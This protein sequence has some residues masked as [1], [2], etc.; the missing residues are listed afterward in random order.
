[1]K[2]LVSH[3]SLYKKNGW[4]R[5]FEEAKGL[6]RLGHDVTLLCSARG[7]GRICNSQ[8]VEGVKVLAFYDII[9]ERFLLFGHG[10]FSLFNKLIY[11]VFTHFDICLSN[12]HR[13]NAYYPCALNRFFHRSK[14]VI[15]WWDDFSVKGNSIQSPNIIRRVI[16]RIINFIQPSDE[17]REISTKLSSDIVVVLSSTMARRAER[18]GVSAD[19]IRII[20]GGCDVDHLQYINQPANEIKQ[21]N[22]IPVDCITFGFIGDGDQELKDLD[23]FFDAMIELKTK[24]KILFLNYGGAFRKAVIYKPE[25]RDIIHECGWVDYHGDNSIL[26][27]TDVFILIKQ[28]NIK[29]QSG[30]PNKFGDYLA[31]GRAVLLNPYGDIIP[32]MQKWQ[33]GVIEVDYSK[34]S[35]LKGIAS[36]CEGMIDLSE[37]AARNRA[38]ALS[39]SWLQ[40]AKELESVFM[41]S[42]GTKTR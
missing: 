39:N 18:V 34:D 20:Y 29:N 15:E 2:I 6:A 19:K 4:G 41:A 13:D 33:P 5:T 24:Y 22:G 23:V 30:W 40:K 31:C 32:F 25:L 12:S 8:E 9:P 3:F 21:N 38:I 14:L 28:N 37:S 17:K 11:S 26:S 16:R 35:I 36:I 1:M 7:F 42:M 10:F 27:A